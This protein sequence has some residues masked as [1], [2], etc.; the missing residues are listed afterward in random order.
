MLREEHERISLATFGGR[1]T[2][3][4]AYLD[5]YFAVFGPYHRYMLHH[6][7]GIALAVARFQ[8]PVRKVAE[9]H[10]IDDLGR[11]PADWSEG[12]GMDL[13]SADYYASMR[14]GAKGCKRGALIQA[15]R[16]LYPDDAH[17]IPDPK[18]RDKY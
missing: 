17:L 1:Y 4:H 12:F 11:V 15:V 10:I 5:Q 6:R 9:Q 13:D 8:G 18:P 16:D 2:E 14:E 7:K 3:I